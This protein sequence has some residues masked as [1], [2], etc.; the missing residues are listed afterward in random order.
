MKEGA[1]SHYT[2]CEGLEP[3]VYVDASIEDAV[4]LHLGPLAK[5]LGAERALVEVDSTGRTVE[6]QVGDHTR[7][8]A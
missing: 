3:A 5:L 8:H 7:V 1:R 6:H 4:V 2:L